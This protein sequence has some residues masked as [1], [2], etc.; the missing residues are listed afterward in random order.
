VDCPLPGG[1][2]LRDRA[3]AL[4]EKARVKL[5]QVYVMP[6]RKA[7][8]ANA[9]ARRGNRSSSPISFSITSASAKWIVY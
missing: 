1:T 3:S 6:T 7:L 4:A 5:Q 2:E 9:L 8:M